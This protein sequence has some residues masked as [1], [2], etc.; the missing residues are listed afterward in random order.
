[1]SANERFRL[2]VL[3]SQA[4][5]RRRNCITFNQTMNDPKIIPASAHVTRRSFLQTSSKA[6]AGGALLGAMPVERFA[7]GASPGDTLRIALVGCGG[8]GSG[9]A[10]QA[11]STTGG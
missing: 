11:L 3:N 1:M 6:I 4:S 2:C 9:A 8:R 7:L 5:R 10:D